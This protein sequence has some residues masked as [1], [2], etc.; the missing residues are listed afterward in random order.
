[1]PSSPAD[2]EPIRRYRRR[3]VA[4]GTGIAALTLAALAAVVLIQ[5]ASS[6]P[7]SVRPDVSVAGVAATGDLAPTFTVEELSGRGEA[8]FVPGQPTVLTFWASWCAPC[9]KEFPLLSRAQ[10]T[11]P[12]I[13]VLGV[14]YKDIPADARSFVTETGA[15]WP[16]AIDDDGDLAQAYGVRAIPQTFFIDRDG[17]IRGRL[18]GFSSASELA[19]QLDLIR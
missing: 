3:L 6:R 5:P 18:Y 14:V 17:V 7:T 2:S 10:Q 11:N 15:T 12:D 1:M 19:T 16:N 13:R 9:R 4:L 8:T